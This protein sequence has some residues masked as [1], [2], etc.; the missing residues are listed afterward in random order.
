MRCGA[1]PRSSLWRR[2]QVASLAVACSLILL[3]PGAPAAAL[4]PA[5]PDSVVVGEAFR[6][7]E[8]G[9]WRRAFQIIAEIEAPLP[10]KAL[11]W[12]QMIEEQE[13]R[14]F[15]TLANF[16]LDN[17]DWPWPEELQIIA[18]GTIT[19]PADHELIRRLF[20]DRAPLTTRGTIRYAEA[21]FKIDQDEPAAALIRRAWVE[22]DFSA[23]EEQKFYN[24]Y[25][26]LLTS[27]DHIA[28]LDNLLWDYRRRSASRMLDR[29]PPGYRRLATAR[30]LLQRR[31]A[32]VDKA[33]AAVPT[34]LQNDSGLVFDRMRWRR[35]K[36]RH[37]DVVELLLD[38]PDNLAHP[39]RWWFERELQVRRALRSRDF[40]L[41][42]RLASR[43]GQTAGEELAAAEWLSG[44]LALRF[45]GQPDT[46]LRHFNRLYEAAEAPVTLARAAY[47]VARSHAAL[48]AHELAAV[49]YRRAAAHPIAYYGQLA[50]EELGPAHRPAPPPPTADAAQ[51]A[52]FE[53]KEL[54][55]LLRMLIEADVA[56]AQLN[57]FLVRLADL[58]ADPAEVGLV[59]ELAA[60]SGRPHLVT[61]TG[62]YAAYYGHVNE[63]AAFPIP[64]LP[65]L[66]RPPAGEPEAALL[67]GIA[68]QESI[69]NPWVSSHAGAQGMLQLMPRTAYLMARSLGLHYNQGL[70]TG[71]PDY[72]IRLG[73]HYMKTLLARYREPA[74]AV[75]AYNAGPRRVD[76]WLSLHGDPR[77]GDRY[78]VIDW[79]ELIPFDETRNYVERVL[80][81][82]NMYRRRLAQREIAMVPFRPVNGPLEP[83]PAPQLKSYEYAR[84]LALAAL[85]ARAPRPVFKPL[86]RH[87]I[88][89]AGFEAAPL[90][91]KLK[92]GDLLAL[93]APAAGSPRPELKPA[94]QS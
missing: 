82:R 19:D 27:Q 7:A 89:P 73:R 61:Q 87:E 5:N 93:V 30:M 36:R 11:R 63:V 76:E 10:A 52:S 60:S 31:A 65:G 21:L 71:N 42:Y 13:P 94:P 2:L 46:A 84:Q 54:V 85:L 74:L 37:N 4:G 35:Q 15:A 64:D 56:A 51:R 50:A 24:K 45:A 57:P 43:H 38:P 69:F 18:E 12:L 72:N 25:R 49:W 58:A 14:D 67:L 91:P 66:V 16:L 88:V 26:R 75:A 83:V 33:I 77:R 6:A 70:L 79:I 92:P 40:D 8:R 20:A 34:E 23:G 3:A 39:T 90:L 53:S 78:D 1:H 32:G 17:P 28:R 86:E 47:W 80:E 48:G 9:E 68:R 59:A 55:R 41:A 81:G 22:G 44:W 29:V 62:R